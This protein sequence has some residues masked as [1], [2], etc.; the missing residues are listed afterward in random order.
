LR[1]HAQDAVR[2]ACWGLAGNR[3]VGIL[4]AYPGTAALLTAVREVADGALVA[5]LV[6]GVLVCRC[7]AQQAHEVRRAFIAAWQVLRPAL[8]DRAAL[9]PRIWA[10]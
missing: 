10:T 6:D 8:L 5:T 7:V 3:A 1:I 9:P 4:V 2:T